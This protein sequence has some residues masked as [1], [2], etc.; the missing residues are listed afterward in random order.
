MKMGHFCLKI[1]KN[2]QT[3]YAISLRLLTEITL[4]QFIKIRIAMSN[5]LVNISINETLNP[6]NLLKCQLD[7]YISL[8]FYRLLMWWTGLRLT[9]I[10]S[11]F[12]T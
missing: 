4:L 12:Y 10:F 6:Q 11:K 8:E 7:N 9:I 2:T 1:V 5:I 3:L